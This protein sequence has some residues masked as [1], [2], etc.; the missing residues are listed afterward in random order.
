MHPEDM[1]SDHA[2]SY[3]FHIVCDD[4]E[5]VKPR[6]KRVRKG[7]ILVRIFVNVVLKEIIL[8]DYETSG[9]ELNI[10]GHKSGSPQQRHY[11]VHSNWCECPPLRS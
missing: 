10:P 6:K 9:R 5:Q 2:I 7:D 1:I 11:T 8:R 4:E 3:F